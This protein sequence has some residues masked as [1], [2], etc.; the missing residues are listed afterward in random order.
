VIAVNVEGVSGGLIEE[1]GTEGGEFQ[2]NWDF[3]DAGMGEMMTLYTR[4]QTAWMLW[5]MGEARSELC[6]SKELKS[7]GS[8]K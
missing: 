6:K 7:A 5:V 8:G 2:R 3:Y 1:L 4:G